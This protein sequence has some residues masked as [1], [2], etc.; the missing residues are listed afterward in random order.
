MSIDVFYEQM[1]KCFYI[2]VAK[3]LK[4]VC[5]PKKILVTRFSVASKDSYFY[6]HM[7]NDAK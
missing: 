1:K 2:F 3:P 4:C 7:L 6:F 5:I